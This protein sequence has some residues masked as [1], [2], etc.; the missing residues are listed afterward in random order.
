MCCVWAWVLE[1][2][3]RGFCLRTHSVMGEKDNG[4]ISRLETVTSAGRVH[5]ECVTWS[6]IYIHFDLKSEW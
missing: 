3:C 1:I 4:E 5:Q 6:Q 2:N